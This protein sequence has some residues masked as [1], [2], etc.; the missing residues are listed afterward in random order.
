VKQTKHT[1]I[2]IL[3][4]LLYVSIMVVISMA[5]IIPSRNIYDK[6][7]N[8]IR[9][10]V[11]D[12]VEIDGSEVVPDNHYDEVVYNEKID[13]INSI[14]DDLQQ[15]EELVAEKL[16]YAGESL[17][18]IKYRY[19]DLQS[20]HTIGHN[21]IIPKV[22]ETHYISDI[23]VGKDK[24][25]NPNIN[26]SIHYDYIEYPILGSLV[27][28]AQ[29]NNTDLKLTIQSL[30][31]DRSGDNTVEK[32]EANP[33]PTSFSHE[34]TYP[35]GGGSP[36]TRTL[37]VE[38]KSNITSEDIF[39]EDNDNFYFNLSFLTTAKFQYLEYYNLV[40]FLSFAS[41]NHTVTVSGKAIEYIPKQV[42]ITFY[43]N[44][45]GIDLVDKTVKIGSGNHPFSIGGN[46]ELLQTSNYIDTVQ[47][48]AIDTDYNNTLT[49]Y[50]NGKETATILCSI[51]DYYDESKNKVIAI[52]NSTNK[53]CFRMY[54][55]VEP[56]VFGANGQDKPLSKNKDGSPKQ[57]QVLGVKPIYDGAVWQELTLQEV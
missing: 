51:S 46:N 17:Y 45:I 49:K 55:I 33:I 21:V 18:H 37:T 19:V 36:T 2:K 56:Y 54:D 28:N 41:G 22:K 24:N 5:I 13:N 47:Y 42:D 50:S 29:K 38:N 30:S 53:M 39:T 20:A 7:H 6:N 32:S 52:D 14:G 26:C 1:F 15:N 34:F 11:I 35:S 40:D 31:F 4:A 16:N 44:T 43:G 12:N 9:D 23:L 57:F 10:N 3:M 27:F 8:K 48:K 25:D